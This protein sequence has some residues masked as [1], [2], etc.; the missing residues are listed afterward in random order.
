MEKKERIISSIIRVIAVAASIYGMCR[1]I[2]DWVGFT[3]FTNL[4][5]I[6]MDIVLFVFLLWSIV[7]KDAKMPN[8]MYIIKYMATISITLTFLVYLCLL[9]P[10]NEGGFL[11]SY[12]KNGA[13]SLCVH[14]VMP[15]LAIFDFV[16]FDYRYRSNWLHA[17]F[18]TIPPLLYVV[19]V[20]VASG[21]GM[22]WYETMYAPYNFLNF[23][24][25]TGWFGWDTSLLSSE[26]LGIGTA[27]M[28]V[29]LLLLFLGIGELY[30]LA[31]NWR[32]KRH[33]GL[34]FRK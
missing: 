29:V 8:W 30:L 33:E 27:Y 20:V 14:M 12:M 22:R 23:G 9:A 13:G 16:I 4:S 21:F 24:A 2:S 26:T 1:T 31:K 17:I 19:Y 3:Y 18:A 32:A 6:F 7:K 15:L 10:T 5:N 28:I 34:S 25:E 11:L